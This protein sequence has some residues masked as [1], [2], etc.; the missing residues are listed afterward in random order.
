MISPPR[1]L[2]PHPLMYT[3]R[4]GTVLKGI[5]MKSHRAT[6]LFIPPV[7]VTAPSSSMGLGSGGSF[8]DPIDEKTP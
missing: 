7:D 2:L 5:P 1:H 4:G 3:L 8:A 6:A